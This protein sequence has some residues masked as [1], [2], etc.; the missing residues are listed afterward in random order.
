M[1]YTLPLCLAALV[2]FALFLTF[3]AGRP[4]STRQARIL[5]ALVWFACFV[6]AILLF[7]VQVK[8]RVVG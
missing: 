5:A 8:V 3:E 6:F 7:G 1:H 4:S 2:A